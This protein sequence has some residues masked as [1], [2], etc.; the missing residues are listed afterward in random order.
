M[1]EPKFKVGDIVRTKRK[2]RN[3]GTFPGLPWGELLLPKGAEGIVIDIG[4]F[5]QTQVVYVVNFL[6]HGKIVGCLE[7]ELEACNEIYSV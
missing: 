5:L 3:D 1:I 2:I 4:R 7:H 6:E